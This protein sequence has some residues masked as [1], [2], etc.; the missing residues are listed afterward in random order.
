MEMNKIIKKVWLMI[1]PDFLLHLFLFLQPLLWCLRPRPARPRHSPPF[2]TDPALSAYDFRRFFALQQT[3]P[4]V[5][6]MISAP[7]QSLVSVPLGASSLLCDIFTR[8]GRNEQI[9][10]IMKTGTDSICF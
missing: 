5:S 3:G 10:K 9:D 4:S 6:E 2:L 1:F 8:L 7:F